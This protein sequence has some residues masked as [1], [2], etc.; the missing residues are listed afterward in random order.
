LDETLPDGTDLGH[1]WALQDPNDWIEVLKITIPKVIEEANASPEEIIGIGVDFTSCTVLPVDDQGQPMC[2]NPEFKNR[3]HAWPKLWK[4]HAAQPEA[5]KITQAITD[6]GD[7]ILER[8]GGKMSSE[9][10][11]PKIWQVLDEDEDI[12]DATARFI[13][14]GDWLV[15]QLCGSEARSSCMAGYKGMWG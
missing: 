11:V 7:P 10:I 4:H 9:W 14:G 6:C 8:Y 5:D 12:Y 1:D 15:V 3:P 13:E 2:N